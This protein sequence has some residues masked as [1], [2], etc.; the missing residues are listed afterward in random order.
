MPEEEV[1]ASL[2]GLARTH[3]LTA[4]DAA[5][6]V[7]AIQT[8]LPLASRDRKLRAAAQRSNVRLLPV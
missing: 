2:L 6:L 4:Y 3:Q 7:L 8:G 1:P 5:Y